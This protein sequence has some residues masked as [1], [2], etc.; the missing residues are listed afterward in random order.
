MLKVFKGKENDF[1]QHLNVSS[2]NSYCLRWCGRV[3][4]KAITI[5]IILYI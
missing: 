4:N 2:L 5:Y 3:D 1:P